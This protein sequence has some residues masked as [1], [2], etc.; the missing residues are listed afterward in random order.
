[1][2]FYFTGESSSDFQDD[3]VNDP[4]WVA[5][6]QTRHLSSESL[7]EEDPVKEEDDSI[8]RVE[9]KKRKL[10]KKKMKKS[11]KD[12]TGVK[13]TVGK[14]SKQSKSTNKETIIH[15]I[16]QKETSSSGSVDKHMRSQN[17]KKHTIGGTDSK[18]ET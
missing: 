11:R 16:C 10:K 6:T 12:Q 5:E 3:T 1:M 7:D 15:P 2:T 4:D 13:T 9:K 17:A 18:K 8:K 14:K